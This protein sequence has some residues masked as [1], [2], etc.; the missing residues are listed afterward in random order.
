MTSRV[1]RLWGTLFRVSLIVLAISAAG[2]LWAQFED[3]DTGPALPEANL[4]GLEEFNESC[5]DKLDANTSGM[6]LEELLVPGSKDAAEIKAYKKKNSI[7]QILHGNHQKRGES[8]YWDARCQAAADLGEFAADDKSIRDLLFEYGVSKYRTENPQ[9]MPATVNSFMKGGTN[10]LPRLFLYLT[11][12]PRWMVRSRMAD[13]LGSHWKLAPEAIEKALLNMLANDPSEDIRGPRIKATFGPY[14][15]KPMPDKLE[16]LARSRLREEDNSYAK[17]FLI[18]YRY[19]PMDIAKKNTGNLGLFRDLMFSGKNW[20]SRWM[21]VEAIRM[22]RQER[23]PAAFPEYERDALPDL[24]KVLRQDPSPRM[25]FGVVEALYPFTNAAAA[26]ALADAMQKDADPDIRAYAGR[27]LGVKLNRVNKYPWMVRYPKTA[28]K[29]LE[30]KNAE[31]PDASVLSKATAAFGRALADP[32]PF[33][34]Y[35]AVMGLGKIN[36]PDSLVLLKAFKPDP[37]TW[38]NDEAAKWVRQCEKPDDTLFLGSG[39]GF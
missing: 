34:R 20:E 39:V 3:L 31:A 19:Y 35:Y 18:W 11:N 5:S 17:Y 2:S 27:M 1:Q 7:F 10:E 32:D 37:E 29:F 9:F 38:I 24:V 23:D 36:T 12:S 6:E 16:Q 15:I 22:G 33:V 26:L 30:K 28:K 8:Y 13:I 4:D 25:R 14:G 21:G